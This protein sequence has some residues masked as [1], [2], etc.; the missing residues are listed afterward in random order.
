MVYALPA[1]R[2]SG[3]LQ[4]ADGHPTVWRKTGRL[5]TLSKGVYV[6]IMLFPN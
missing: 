5:Q 1:R 6:I 3:L 4:Q 2:G